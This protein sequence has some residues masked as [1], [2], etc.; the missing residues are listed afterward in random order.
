MAKL[1]FSVITLA[2]LS[3]SITSGVAATTPPDCTIELRGNI[4]VETIENIK[5]V[6]NAQSAAVKVP[7]TTTTTTTTV[8]KPDDQLSGLISSIAAI[9][10]TTTSTVAVPSQQPKGVKPLIKPDRRGR[11]IVPQGYTL[12]EAVGSYDKALKISSS[13]SS[14]YVGNTINGRQYTVLSDPDSQAWGGKCYWKTPSGNYNYCQN[15]DNSGKL[16]E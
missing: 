16:L 14:V 6:P 2:T 13:L 9:Q 15:T 5:C 12:A 4:S 7:A 10:N 3:F 8:M 1:V 11:Y